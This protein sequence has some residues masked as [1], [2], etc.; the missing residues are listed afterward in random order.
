MEGELLAQR[1]LGTVR[2]E[3]GCEVGVQAAVM[4]AMFGATRVGEGTRLGNFVNVGHGVEVGARGWIAAGAILGGHAVIVG[5]G[6][7][8]LDD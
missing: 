6:A 4:R 1:H 5:E 7:L 2:I 8:D 3:A